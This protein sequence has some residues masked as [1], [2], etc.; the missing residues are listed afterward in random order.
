MLNMKKILFIFLT[1]IILLQPFIVAAYAQSD[2]NTSS[3]THTTCIQGRPCSPVD[4]ASNNTLVKAAQDLHDAYTACTNGSGSTYYNGALQSCLLSHLKNYPSANT[5]LTVPFDFGADGGSYGAQGCV[6]CIGYVRQA[7]ALAYGTQSSL[8]GN[9]GDNFSSPTITV[10]SHVFKNL[11][12]VPAQPGDIAIASGDQNSKGCLDPN[13]RVCGAGHIL[14]VKQG[15]GNIKFIG[16]EANWS[17]LNGI[18]YQEP[19]CTVTD[20]VAHPVTDYNIFRDESVST[21]NNNSITKNANKQAPN[22][23]AKAPKKGAWFYVSLN[24]QQ[25]YTYENGKKLDIYDVSTGKPSDDTPKTTGA[26]VKYLGPNGLA[27]GAPGYAVDDGVFVGAFWQL[28]PTGSGNFS[29]GY[30]KSSYLIH[31]W[32]FITHPC[33]T[34]PSG[35]CRDTNGGFISDPLPYNQALGNT[36]QSHGCIRM[37]PAGSGHLDFYNFT[38]W[39]QSMES[40]YKTVPF[41]IGD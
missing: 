4:N 14:I 33:N 16:L 29:N 18:T 24:N 6:Q 10:G 34:N 21:Q 39:A 8:A 36:P 11:G 32:P 9:A 25:M 30:T 17:N 28:F 5:Q 3:D 12:S 7:L 19:H 1:S 20:N 38:S 22:I 13:Q 31:P 15:Q 23:D 26:L 40:K 41:E 27:S 2:P 37:Y 35:Q